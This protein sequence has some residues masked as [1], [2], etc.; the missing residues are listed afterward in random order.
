MIAAFG[1]RAGANRQRVRSPHRCL[2]VALVF[3]VAACTGTGPVPPDTSPV[4]V[5]TP[6]VSPVVV[7]TQPPSSSGSPTACATGFLEGRLT[8]DDRWGVALQDETGS[9]RKIVWP[10]GFAARRSIG[11]LVL[12]DANGRVVARTGDLLSVG[13]SELEP[14]GTWIAC[15]DIRQRD[16]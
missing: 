13:G 6:D 2:A 12:V 8:Q 14:G 16:G 4:G 10:W 5:P 11:G 1:D 7:P 3:G 15:D 9:V